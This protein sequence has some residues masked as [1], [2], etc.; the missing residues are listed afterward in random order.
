MNTYYTSLGKFLWLFWNKS[1]ILTIFRPDKFLG[2]FQV[3]NLH[4][5]SCLLKKTLYNGY[6]E[7]VD[8]VLTILY[9]VRTAIYQWKWWNEISNGLTVKWI[10]YHIYKMHLTY[11]S[12]KFELKLFCFGIGRK[13]EKLSY[14]NLM[15]NLFRR[16]LCWKDLLFAS[17]WATGK[18]QNTVLLTKQKLNKLNSKGQSK[19]EQTTHRSRKLFI[20]SYYVCQQNTLGKDSGK[21]HLYNN[22]FI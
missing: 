6:R 2:R 9:I 15:R 4:F 1:F 14:L 12:W 11:I 17:V 7:I 21:I 22:T 5:W 16:F 20:L 10:L 13:Y 18:R 19:R 3:V 8:T